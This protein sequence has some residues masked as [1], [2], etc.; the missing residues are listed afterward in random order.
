MK[1]VASL[2]LIIAAVFIIVTILFI[3]SSGSVDPISQGES[4]TITDGWICSWEGSADTFE[5]SLPGTAAGG[6][7]GRTLHLTNTLPVRFFNNPCLMFRTSEQYMTV[8]LNGMRIYRFI[9]ENPRRAPGSMYHFINLPAGYES[10]TLEIFLT[11]SLN[12]FSGVV[13]EVRVGS[14]TSHILYI[15]QQGSV[16][17]ILSVVAIILGLILFTFYLSMYFSGYNHPGIL[18]LGFFVVFSGLWMCCESRALELFIRNPMLI[19]CV[20]FMSQYLAPIPILAFVIDTFKPKYSHWL[21]RFLYIFA[22][23]FAVTSILYLFNMIEFYD[24]AILFHSLL[25][26]C[27]VIVMLTAVTEMR[28]GRKSAKLFFMGCIVLCLTICADVLRYYFLSLPWVVKPVIYQYGIFIFMVTTTAALAQ[29]IFLTREEKIGHDILMS[30]AFTDTLTGFNNRRSFD[31]R[32]A[33][34]NEEIDSYSS[35]HLVILDIN[36]LKQVNDTLGH[37]EGDQLIV[38]G[39]RLIN[40]TLGNLGEIFRIGGDEFVALITN[41]ESYFIQIELDNLNKKIAAFNENGAVFQISIAY[42]FSSYNKGQDKDLHDV[43]VRADKSMYIC[44]ENQKGRIITAGKTNHT[45]R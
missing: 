3:T 15:L 14:I 24:T 6:Y 22:A 42:G 34:I 35:I 20:A 37:R 18:Y 26:C 25:V 16:G 40:E 5:L 9:P 33:A 41:I 39:S 7:A 17:L 10:G 45:E 8:Y 44:K 30:L 31:E 28:R 4:I 13:N 21:K 1:K 12:Q 27:V 38:A 36:G 11:S 32:M 23:H 43:F 19:M 29:H 2:V